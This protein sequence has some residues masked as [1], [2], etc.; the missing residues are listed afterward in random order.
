[1]VRPNYMIYV[2]SIKLFDNV[3]LRT[4]FN[5]CNRLDDYKQLRNVA[6]LVPIDFARLVSKKSQ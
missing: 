4:L 1:M 6:V 5:R 2:N 3:R